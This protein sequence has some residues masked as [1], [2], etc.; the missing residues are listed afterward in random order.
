MAFFPE[1]T[2]QQLIDALLNMKKPR[3]KQ[4][5]FLKVHLELPGTAATMPL[6][7]QAVGY[8]TYRAA[9]L[10]YGNLAARIAQALGYPIPTKADKA[11]ALGLLV[12]F[13][14]PEQRQS[15]HITFVMR[16]AFQHALVAAGWI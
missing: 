16:P 2:S 5:Q 9:N 7:A 3:G 12:E 4:C 1:T 15:E 13:V 6:L 14:P 11:T 8:K 10:V